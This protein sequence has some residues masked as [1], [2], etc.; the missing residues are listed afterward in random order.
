MNIYMGDVSS[1]TLQVVSNPIGTAP[2]CPN[3]LQ[4]PVVNLLQT[5]Q[6]TCEFN[7][8]NLVFLPATALMGPIPLSDI[9]GFGIPSAKWLLVSIG[10]WGGL[11]WLVLG[12]GK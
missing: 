3:V 6:W 8:S 10:A 11:L 4:S 1:P 7:V 12:S 2:T 9:D 5:P